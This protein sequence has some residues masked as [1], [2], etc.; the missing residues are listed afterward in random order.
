M[1]Q[2]VQSPLLTQ[3]ESIARSLPAKAQEDFRQLMGGI[4]DNVTALSPG[5]NLLKIGGPAAGSSKAPT[6]VTHAVAGANGQLSVQITNPQTPQG[7]Q[8]LHEFSYSPVVSFKGTVTTLP[9][10][11]ATSF[12]VPAVG[13]AVYTRLRSSYDGVNWSNYT[14]SSTT[15][16]DAGFVESSAMSSGGAFNQTNFAEVGSQ[17]GGSG[18]ALVTIGGPGG[19]LTPYAAVKGTAQVTRPSA[20]VAGVAPN[21]TQF[22]G[23]DGTTFRLKPTLAAVLADDLEPVGKV[24]VVS[25]AAP[26]NPTIVPVISGGQ[27]VGYDVTSGGSGASQSY[28]LALATTGGGVGATFGAQTIQNG[29][30]IAVAP[31]NPGSGY[32]GLTSVVVTGGSPGGAS[33]GGT[34]AGGNGGRMTAV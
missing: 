26:V 22:V 20:T 23:Y 1:S 32:G 6:G 7:T 34:A 17:V 4:I 27:I 28:N 3:V 5:G 30:L 9:P 2:T 19:P 18:T 24:S 10:T 11:T 15:P 8:I 14:L 21:S 33:G 29:V 31:G 16:T 25:T 12:Q 13:Q